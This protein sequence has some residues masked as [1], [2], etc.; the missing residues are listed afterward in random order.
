MPRAE[1]IFYKEG[2]T[3]LFAQWL[4]TL[5]A[6]VQAKCLAQISLLRLHGY[7][8]R[9]PISDFLRDGIY[10]LRPVYQG[11]NYRILYFF[12]GQNIAVISHGITKESKIPAVE[13]NRAIEH[14]KL[15][16]ANPKAHAWKGES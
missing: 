15:F 11:V 5:P 2:E 16:A 6:K 13:I 4:D 12:A 1:V 10:E 9:R 8:L 14:K 7:E 3:V